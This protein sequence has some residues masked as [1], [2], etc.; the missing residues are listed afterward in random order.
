MAQA[1]PQVGFADEIDTRSK[2]SDDHVEPSATFMRPAARGT[3]SQLQQRTRPRPDL[4]LPDE[5][6]VGSFPRAD[7]RSCVPHRGRREGRLSRPISDSCGR[8]ISGD[9]DAAFFEEDG[10]QIS[11]DQSAGKFGD[12][13]AVLGLEMP[14]AMLNQ[15]LVATTRQHGW[16][17]GWNAR[18]PVHMSKAT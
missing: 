14:I 5:C 9:T 1:M 16:G 11:A 4:R 7:L 15:D 10:F 3:L 12:L 13:F 6:Y 2:D 17:E 8:N 18:A